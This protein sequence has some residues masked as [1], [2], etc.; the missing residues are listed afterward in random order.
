MCAD[1]SKCMSVSVVHVQERHT[2]IVTALSRVSERV[3][4]LKVVMVLHS[5]CL[6]L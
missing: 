2:T 3:L 4:W 5:P 1:P 6:F